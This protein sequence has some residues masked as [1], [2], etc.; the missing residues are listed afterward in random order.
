MWAGNKNMHDSLSR[1]HVKNVFMKQKGFGV[2]SLGRQKVAELIQKTGLKNVLDIPC[3]NCVMYEVLKKYIPDIDYYGAD[4]TA[5][6]IDVSKELYP[7]LKYKLSRDYI[8][9]TEFNNDEFDIV[10]ARHIFEHIPDWKAAMFECLRIARKYVYYVFYIPPG[11]EERI[12]LVKN[13]SGDYYLNTYREKDIIKQF[14]GRRYH[15]YMKISDEM[16]PSKTTDI[17]YEVGK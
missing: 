1:S 5:Q 10:I 8:Q 15:K 7:E 17:I 6:M 9:A 2:D 3:C 12:N 13:A 14:G 11:K 4:L 16:N